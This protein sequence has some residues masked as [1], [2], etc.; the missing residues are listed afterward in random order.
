MLRGNFPFT[1][2]NL[3]AP[4]WMYPTKDVVDISGG[5]HSLVLKKDGTVYACGSNG[6]GQCAQFNGNKVPLLLKVSSLSKVKQVSAG[7]VH[8][9]ALSDGKVYGFGNSGV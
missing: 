9:L 3:A 1:S 8:S 5:E 4:A 7:E 6:D 2:T